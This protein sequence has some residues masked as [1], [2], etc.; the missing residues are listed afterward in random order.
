MSGLP[1][2]NNAEPSSPNVPVSKASSP[3][4][5]KIRALG[6]FTVLI[7][8]LYSG[9]WFYASDRI[10]TWVANQIAIGR[11]NG[12]SWTCP[13]MDIR[14]YPFRVGLYCRSIEMEDSASGLSLKAGKLQSAAQVYDPGHSI[15]ELE[16]PLDVRTGNGVRVNATWDLAHASVV[17][18]LK[19]L[20]RYSME[21][22][23]LLSRFTTAN[24]AS[25]FSV[26]TPD[27][28][29]HIRQN[30]ADLDLAAD[31][32]DATIA[33]PVLQM[34]IPSFTFAADFTLAGQA[35]LLAGVP[36]TSLHDQT[37]T[38]RQVQIDAGANGRVSI[39]GPL[40]IDNY[41]QVS[42][43]ITVSVDKVE[44]LRA[45][46]TSL[47]PEITDTANMV[48]PMLTGMAKADGSVTLTLT[49]SKG[50]VSLGLIPLGIIPPL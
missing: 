47:F 19:G 24:P 21:M 32:Q 27:G 2:A 40:T 26:A 37:V 9:T 16:G 14:G 5:W 48:A 15:V 18:D 49:V 39:S 36:L 4:V 30:G 44:A 22:K 13:D 29:I 23:D 12:Q 41:G 33:I 3:T 17:A 1:L 28:Q 7:V 34:A 25:E 46:V 45:T 38:I 10:K 6:I 43:T 20:N 11:E 42:G 50:A 35:G 31:M 8:L